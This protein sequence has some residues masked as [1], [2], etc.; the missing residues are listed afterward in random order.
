MFGGQCDG[1]DVLAA[2][3]TQLLDPKTLRIVALWCKAHRGAR[4]VHQQGSQVDIAALADAKQ[5]G[6][7]AAG[8]LLA[9]LT[10]SYTSPLRAQRG[11][12]KGEH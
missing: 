12:A 11:A 8:I 1:R 9:L 7:A 5:P 4:A 3:L 2:A 10:D 6:L